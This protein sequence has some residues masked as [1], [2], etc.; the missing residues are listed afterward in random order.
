[1]R[2]VFGPAC[3]VLATAGAA[4]GR[5]GQ[6]AGGAPAREQKALAP[7]GVVLEGIVHDPDGAWSRLQ[8]GVGG[9]LAL[10]PASIGRLACA[11]LGVDAN[12]AALVDGHAPA[13]A[14]VVQ[15]GS[16]VTPPR[17]DAADAASTPP[18]GVEG[19]IGWVVAV[20]LTADGARRAAA[21]AAP[22]AGLTDHVE[23]GMHV[24][25]RPDS[26]LPAAIGIAPGWLVIARDERDLLES[27]PYAFKAM[28]E[29]ASQPSLASVV[30]IASQG[31]LV[32]PVA[33]FLSSR[34]AAARDWLL[35]QG[36]VER[37][38]HGG[39]RPDFADPEAIVAALEP[40]VQRRLAAIARAR[41]VRIE[42]EIGVDDIS[43][44]LRAEVVEASP[45][46]A[47][48]SPSA[49][50][51]ASP[52]AGASASPPDA[53]RPSATLGDARPLA[54]SPADA[55]LALLVRDDAAERS[56]DAR[57]LTGVLARVLGSR[58]RDD[59]TR[60]ID[61][62]LDDWAR[63]RGDWMAVGLAEP[64]A[65]GFWVR[66]PA[67]DA[68]I[69][70]RAVREVL[71]LSRLPP[72]SSPL[73]GWLHRL[74]V[75]F[76]PPVGGVS[77]A[78]FPS[79]PDVGPRRAAGAAWDVIG[80]DLTIGVGTMPIRSLAEVA[81]PRA[82]WG[83]DPRTARV[84]AALGDTTSLAVLAQPLRLGGA[85]LAAASAPLAFAWGRH[86]ADP[87]GRIDIADELVAA[88]V[89]LSGGL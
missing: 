57:A 32:G 3:V 78:T 2:R 59:E 25:T 63:G 28:P 46:G 44:E 16:A 83:D 74:P 67:A 73:V 6:D 43:V 47:S 5:G 80:G 9:A 85:G 27:G 56:D 61:A 62:A 8:H 4:C 50:A 10:L 81:S 82:S 18:G 7:E 72:F 38:R 48:A 12:L 36:R 51:S 11:A 89:R 53:P 33:A 17:V 69:A 76:G 49:G 41:D 35:E 45:A 71:E 75:V 13:Y 77:V 20:R 60:A 34:W 88:A 30:A 68:A 65:G 31:A 86:G 19:G 23:G 54:A 24:L 37:E 64:T 79:A 42:G 52:P 1:V 70:S 39:R 21:M 87:W 26:P 15:H 40:A 84:L 58:L 14:V 22:P 55:P 29:Q 66:S